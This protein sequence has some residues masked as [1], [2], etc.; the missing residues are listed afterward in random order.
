VKLL[1]CLFAETLRTGGLEDE[2]NRMDFVKSIEKHTDQLTSLVDDLLDLSRIESGQK[3]PQKAQF[4]L[5]DLINDVVRD[6]KPL[7]KA[8]NIEI[9]TEFSLMNENI[10]AD[11]AQIRQVL[12][13]LLQNAI[14]FNQAKGHVSISSRNLNEGIA[15]SVQDTGFGIPSQDLPRIFERF[16][17]VDKGRSRDMGGTGL[18]LS[19][20]KHIVEAH[21]GS[22]S[23]ESQIGKGSTFTFTLPLQ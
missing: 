11:K 12:I 5:I 6:V 3:Q 10:I 2:K 16:Y 14:K 23:V 22:I 20:V 8:H 9:K 17:R 21:K 7:T 1:G 15:I 18:G 13:N 4:N 19:I